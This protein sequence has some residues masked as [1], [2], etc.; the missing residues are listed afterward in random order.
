MIKNIKYKGITR[1][2][3]DRDSFD[4]EL[5]EAINITNIAGELRPY[6]TPSTI[7]SI[8]GVLAFVHKNSGYEHLISLDGVTIKAYDYK[9]GAITLIGNITNIY[10]ENFIKCESIGNTL[11]IL[12]D[13]EVKYSLW[14]NNSY[15]Y[16][17]KE[18]PFPEITFQLSNLPGTGRDYSVDLSDYSADIT[19]IRKT[20]VSPGRSGRASSI[21]RGGTSGRYSSE[22]TRVV[23]EDF[24]NFIKGKINSTLNQ[25]TGEKAFV[26]PFFLRYAIRLYDGSLIRHSQPF[27]MLPSRFIPF[28]AGIND[29]SNTGYFKFPAMQILYSNTV[30]NLSNYSDIISSV[31]IFMSEPVYTYNQDEVI[32]GT[33]SNPLRQNSPSL[34]F[35]GIYQENEDTLKEISEVSNF[36]KIASFSIHEFLISKS[37]VPLKVE[38][39][40][41]V[42]QQERMTDDYLSHDTIA[43][44]AS[45]VYN[46]KL[47]LAG[48]TRTPFP[49]FK[50]SGQKCY[51][52]ASNKEALIDIGDTPYIFYPGKAESVLL[53]TT[54][55]IGDTIY[56]K[57]MWIT[58]NPHPFLNGS[59]YLNPNLINIS[60]NAELSPISV[61]SFYTQPISEKDKLYVSAHQNPFLFPVNSR[62][63]LPVSKIIGMASNTEPI[64]QGQFG[65]FPLYVF[66]D[67]GVWALEIDQEGKYLARQPVSRDVCINPNILQMDKYIGFVTEKGL[68]I[69]SGAQTECIT[70][71]IRDNNIRASKIPVSAILTATGSESFAQIY[72]TDN[73]EVFMK[74]CSLAYEYINGKGRI[75][76][77]NKN[78]T[79]SYVF[80]IESKSWGKIQSDFKQAVNNYPDCYVQD[81]DGRILNLSSLPSSEDQK[82]CM[83]VTRA[84]T[85]DDALFAI[86]SFIHRGIVKG[87]LNTVVY[88]S[89]DGQTYTPIASSRYELISMRGTP[90]KYFKIAVVADLYPTDV[91]SGCTININ[92]RYSN[93]LR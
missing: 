69:L 82:K 59:Y 67:D 19:K 54:Q 41:N 26:F 64:S 3:S 84:L 55:W 44:E 56:Y 34:L 70:D 68:T 78:Y 72:N 66:T 87:S 40:E 51:Y 21:A 6:I 16:L 35:G 37:G 61:I 32:N 18:L 15:I 2:P 8:S 71:I 57:S 50:I 5:E 25:L 92:E 1:I 76:M 20:T 93:R 31:D 42:V 39:V 7:G 33:F 81:L 24:E 17:G 11:I 45:F 23:S 4:G 91:I 90:Y 77:I 14:K 43:T 48:I 46:N 80:D 79:Y 73:I 36:Y 29:T 28:E 62:I 86:N 38:T 83:F 10:G 74:N 12:T 9:N 89:R 22:N 47:H 27:L 30:V 13:K 52:S 88:G 65:Q 75:F 85:H 53:Q 60:N 58:L 63:T 49:G